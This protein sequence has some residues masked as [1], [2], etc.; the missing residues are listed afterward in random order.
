MKQLTEQ[1][2]I[3][4][5]QREM[6][7]NYMSGSPDIAPHSHNGSD[8]LNIN[9]VD[10]VGWTP[11]PTTNQR[12]LNS[13]TGVYEYGFGSTAYQTGNGLV[14][15]DSTHLSQYVANSSISQYPIPIVVGS[16]VGVTGAFNAGYAPEGTLVFFAN[17]G[18]SV[19]YIRFDGGWRGASFNLSA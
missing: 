10:L 8:G 9:P 16:G 17:G 6:Q 3:D 18:S 4:I 1:D 14:G 19:L 12:Y 7:K 11:I 2:V 15:G 13:V 5:V